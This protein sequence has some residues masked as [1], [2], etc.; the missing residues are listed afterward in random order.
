ML[1]KIFFNPL[2][3]TQKEGRVGV[4]TFNEFLQDLH[5]VAELLGKLRMFLVLPSVAQGGEPRLEERH[6]VL[7]FGVETLE[8][9]REAPDFAGIHDGLWHVRSSCLVL[10]GR[11]ITEWPAGFQ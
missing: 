7:G 4:G 5:R 2:R 8:F 10:S 3:L 9:F 6:P 1:V 11:K